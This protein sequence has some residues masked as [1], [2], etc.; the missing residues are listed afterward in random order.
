MNGAD[1]DPGWQDVRR[2]GWRYLVPGLAQRQPVDDGLVA[3]RVSWVSFAATVAVLGLVAAGVAVAGLGVGTPAGPAA[4]GL[5]I[6]GAASLAAPSLLGHPLD[7]AS[8]ASLAHSYRAR[9]HLHLALAGAPSLAA[10]AAVL[11]TGS[12]LPYPVGAIFA[13]LGLWRL[14]PS[15]ARLAVQQANLATSG[16]NRSLVA[17]LRADG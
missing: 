4:A 6:L 12:W 2:P 13:G 3:L 8:D 16:C 14:T 10:F 17:C 5:A 9:F 1:S 7:C 15:A 11:L